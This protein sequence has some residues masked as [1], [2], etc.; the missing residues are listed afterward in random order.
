MPKPQ[1]VS[2]AK[3]AESL[4]LM[5][6]ILTHGGDGRFHDADILPLKEETGSWRCLCG[7]TGFGGSLALQDHIEWAENH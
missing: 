3:I 2:N 1:R 4:M 6:D 5:D 7:R